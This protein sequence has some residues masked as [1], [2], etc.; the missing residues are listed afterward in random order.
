MTHQKKSSNKSDNKLTINKKSR[1]LLFLI[2]IIAFVFRFYGINWD[3]GHHLHPDERMI[4][5]V[6][7]GI[8]LPKPLTLNTLLSP[9]SPL[10]PK[11]FAYGSLPIYLLKFAG[12]LL[13]FSDPSLAHYQGLLY[14]GRFL[15][16]LFELGT[17]ILIFKIAKKLLSSYLAMLLCCFFYALS[18]L[19]I[20]TSHFYVVD[21][22]LTF[23]ITL[24]L[25]RLLK[26]NHKPSL[27]YAAYTGIAFGLALA[28]KISAILLII[29]VVVTL[30]L[31]FM[32]KRNLFS[33]FK[34]L[35]L[36]F[37]FSF[38]IFNLTMPYALID[39]P[40]FKANTLEQSRMTKDAFVFPYTLQYVNTTPYFYQLK[41]MVL[42]G[43]GIPL[44][45]VSI[46]GTV[47]VSLIVLKS[48]IQWLYGY[49]VI[50]LKKREKNK[51]PAIQPSNHLTI[52]LSFF[53]PYLLITGS[54]AIKF[55][56]YWLPI[57]PLFCI[58]GGLFLSRVI[59]LLKTKI[60]SQF[61]F[62]FLCFNVFMIFLWPLSFISIYSHPNTR[63][64]AT[65]WIKEN[66]GQGSTL[67]VEHWDDRVPMSGKYQFLEMP[68]YEPDQSEQKWEIVNSNLEKT[69]YLIIASNRLYVPLMKL[70]DCEK[71][72]SHR[73]YPKTAEYYQKLFDGSLGFEKIAEFSSYPK[74]PFCYVATWLP[75]YVADDSA[76]ESFTVYDHPKVIIFKK[77][78]NN[79]N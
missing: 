61:V 2:I 31:I 38:L 39:F 65:E 49:M 73:C 56:R 77:T 3:N 53:F 13:S 44:G 64:Q 11:F 55:M 41:N 66:I 30:A 16:I 68:M 7:E 20:Q 14:V 21:I 6:A 58:F 18:V 37:T 10:N 47:F 62:M 15:S 52:L 24:T 60:R 54:F 35:I 79:Q 5:M 34:F 51:N 9:N 48:W 67:S 72:P 12:N 63:V 27:K 45:V 29:P 40:T 32:K 50:W 8:R 33:T 23:F 69:D 26:L 42:W 59:I 71:L 78:S 46:V 74:L 19:A 28:T 76:D 1:G 17:I 43:M 70:T 36:I 22:P 57:Y 25:Y 75:C 4:T